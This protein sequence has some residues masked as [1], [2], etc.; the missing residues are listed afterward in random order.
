MNIITRIIH[1]IFIF[2]VILYL[3]YSDFIDQY[4]FV[5]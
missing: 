1:E 3:S 2:D 5:S 4:F